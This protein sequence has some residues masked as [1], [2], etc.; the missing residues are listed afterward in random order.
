MVDFLAEASGIT[1]EPNTL[2]L[3]YVTYPSKVEA[4][5]VS[6]KLV[7]DHLVACANIFPEHDAV[8]EWDGEIEYETEV[9]VIYKTTIANCEKVRKAVYDLHPYD[10]PCFL[11]FDVSGGAD[12]FVKWVRG[13]VS[14]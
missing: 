1:G 13:Q 12:D 5:K 11:T 2:L 14:A 3:I 9:A 7:Q 6:E 10:T 4:Q 8:F